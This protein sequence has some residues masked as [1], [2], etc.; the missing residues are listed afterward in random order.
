MYSLNVYMEEIS[1]LPAA[2]LMECA[3]SLVLTDILVEFEC[4][5]RNGR[6]RAVVLSLDAR[7]M[8]CDC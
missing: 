4:S 6:Q 5:N 2:I 8:Y 7:R 1:L 3:T